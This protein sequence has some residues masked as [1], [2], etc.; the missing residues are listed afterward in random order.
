MKLFSGILILLPMLLGCNSARNRN[1]AVYGPDAKDDTNSQPVITSFR[2]FNK[3]KNAHFADGITT[4]KGDPITIPSPGSCGDDGCALKAKIGLAIPPNATN[5]KIHYF[6]TATNGDPL[7]VPVEVQPG[8][9]Y[10]TEI[11][12]VAPYVGLHEQGFDRYWTVLQAN[13][14]NRSSQAQT[15][16]MSA[17][18]VAPDPD[19]TKFPSPFEHPIGNIVEVR[20]TMNNCNDYGCAV[21]GE[22]AAECPPP[23]DKIQSIHYYG[24]ATGHPY[25][26][27]LLPTE[28]PQGDHG[29]SEFKS[30]G[31]GTGENGGQLAQVEFGNRAGSRTRVATIVLDCGATETADTKI[32]K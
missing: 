21:K 19:P 7:K 11:E 2:W 18:F 1:A 9:L 6:S 25:M 26:D 10:Y 15:F 3:G 32:A 12:P 17:D 8:Q 23:I 5:I 24:N 4:A 13:L 31:T 14:Y 27:L 29:W 20:G 22:I 16:S 30:Q 28:V